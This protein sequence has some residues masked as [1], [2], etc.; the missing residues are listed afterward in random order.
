MSQRTRS[1]TTGADVSTPPDPQSAPSPDAHRLLAPES[2]ARTLRAVADELERDPELA[3]RVAGRLSP[4]DGVAA[5][6]ATTGVAEEHAPAPVDA[7]PSMRGRG[8]TG[9]RKRLV[10]GTD[11]GLGTGIP[12][13]FALYKRLGKA[14]LREALS[15]LRAGT[16]RAIIREHH[17]DP[18]QSMADINDAAKLRAAI[19]KATTR[20]K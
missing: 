1:H 11:P 13:P 19:V 3:R 10:P 17:L 14:G 6:L 9:S 12:D 20:R 8:S 18:E 7:E 4:A 5:A 16:L 2:L 15:E